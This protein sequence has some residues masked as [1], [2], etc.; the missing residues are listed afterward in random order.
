MAFAEWRA[1]QPLEPGIPAAAELASE[2]AL[3]PADAPA[4]V[5]SPAG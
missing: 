3:E 1:G 4:N 5:A 2:D